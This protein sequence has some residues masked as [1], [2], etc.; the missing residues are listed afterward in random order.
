[1]NALLVPRLG[2]YLL[3]CRTLTVPYCAGGGND[4]CIAAFATYGSSVTQFGLLPN[5]VGVPTSGTANGAG[6]SRVLTQA[7]AAFAPDVQ[8]PHRHVISQCVVGLVWALRRDIAQRI[9]GEAASIYCGGRQ[10]S[11]VQTSCRS[12]SP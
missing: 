12:R 10:A 5:K 11:T 8:L 6:F 3:T 7:L 2:T 4:L 9:D 1:M